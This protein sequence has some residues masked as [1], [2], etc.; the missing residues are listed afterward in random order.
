MQDSSEAIQKAISD[1]KRCG[2]KCNGSTTKN[3]I[4]YFPSGTYK[5]SRSIAVYFGTQLIGD[6][7]NKP[8]I[9]ASK[10]HLGLGVFATD[11]YVPNGGTGPDGKSLEWYINTARF[12]SQIRNL[13]VDIRD[14]RNGSKKAAFHYQ[15]A[16]ATTIENIEIMADSSTDQQGIFAE[17]GSGGVMSDIVFKGGKYGIYGGSQQFS[18]SRMTFDGCNTAVQLIWDWG[19]LWKKITVKNVKVGFRLY[20]DANQEIPGSATFV[21]S[22]FENIGDAAILMES[23]ADGQDKGFTGLVLDNVKLGGAVRDKDSNKEIIPIGYHEHVSFSTS[24]K[25]Y[26][27]LLTASSLSLVLHTKATSEAGPWIPCPTS[28]KTS[29]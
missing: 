21:D 2:E 11:V 6:A 4:V 25:V 24:S 17:N 14:V 23:P 18:A 20:N 9:K 1:G 29:F 19:W 3:A 8:M 13:V 27:R 15:V 10:F 22:V 7:N 12:Y 16:Q 28:V 26:C 5:V